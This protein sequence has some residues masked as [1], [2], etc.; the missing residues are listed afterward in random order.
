VI[1]VARHGETEWNRQGRYQGRQDSHLT[2]IGRLQA[3]ALARALRE[4]PVA[5]II[6]SPLARCVETAEPLA[7]ELCLALETDPRLLEIAHGDWEG[8]LR[9]EIARDDPDTW[10]LWREAPERVHFRGG[11]SL[12]DVLLR[13]RSFTRDF[14]GND[15]AVVVTHDAVVRLAI[16]DATGRDRSQLWEPRVI[17]AAYAT[18]AAGPPWA[19]IAPCVDEHLDGV[20]V[21]PASQA[22]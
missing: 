18:F 1:Y 22:L 15:E 11:E 16:L 14:S 8:R 2:Q 21:D 7:R 19:L 5:R 4:R 6:A 10:R 17:N 12:A 9:S 3:E 13:W 20:T